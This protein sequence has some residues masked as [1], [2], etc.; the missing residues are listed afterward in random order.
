MDSPD[1]VLDMVGVEVEAI[2]SGT[3]WTGGTGE[4]AGEIKGGGE[5]VREFVPLPFK[6]PS[7]ESTEATLDSR[8]FRGR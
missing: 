2:K 4:V 1:V 6:R 8:S 3:A 5:L 7:W